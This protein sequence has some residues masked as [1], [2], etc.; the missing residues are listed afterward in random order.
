MNFQK[1]VSDKVISQHGADW[2]RLSLDPFNDFSYDVEGFPDQISTQSRV[3]CHISSDS[4]VA[5]ST[6]DW[7]ARVWMNSHATSSYSNTFHPL[8]TT[9]FN[10]DVDVSTSRGNYST[11]VV[12]SFNVG[13]NPN[14]GSIAA[15]TF[16]RA[17]TGTI[18]ASSPGRLLAVGIEIHNVTPE[19]YKSGTITCS[20][21]GNFQGSVKCLLDDSTSATPAV[22]GN[23]EMDLARLPPSTVASAITR[24]GTTQWEAA[25]GAY[26]FTRL[27]GTELPIEHLTYRVIGYTTGT[28]SGMEMTS[29][30]EEDATTARI[31]PKMATMRH[32]LDRPFIYL[33]GLSPETVL[34]VTTR[35][36]VEYFPDYSDTTRLRLSTPSPAY[37]AEALRLYGQI[38]PHLPMAVPVSMNAKGDYFSLVMKLL[39]NVLKTSAPAYSMIHPAGPAI[40]QMASM[41]AAK[42]AE[43]N[44][45]QQKQEAKPKKKPQKVGYGTLGGTPGDARRKAK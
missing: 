36:Y 18:S 25:K 34:N 33:T 23:V 44:S 43:K 45:R 17:A 10:Y 40:A 32:G 1:L 8:S 21:M 27:A 2:L 24:P 30:V 20:R 22:V 37:D 6:V 11:V 3:E 29:P 19:L 42:L 4:I 39:S 28:L 9:N 35:V 31:V 15:G 16:A 38:A 26:I 5:P 13:T 14:T 12:D 41:V 7:N